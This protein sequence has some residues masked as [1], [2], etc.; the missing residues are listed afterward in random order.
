MHITI[1]NSEGRQQT[2]TGFA[3]THYTNYTCQNW[4][5]ILRDKNAESFTKNMNVESSRGI[6]SLSSHDISNEHSSKVPLFQEREDAKSYKIGTRSEPPPFN[7]NINFVKNWPDERLYFDLAWC[8]AANH[9]CYDEI[10][11]P[12]FESWKVFN[13]MVT[14]KWLLY[15]GY[16]TI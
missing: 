14:D 1:K 8:V 6:K 11:M 15:N 12:P 3:T 2:F 4:L 5:L 9:S 10:E 16:Y 7:S 13:S